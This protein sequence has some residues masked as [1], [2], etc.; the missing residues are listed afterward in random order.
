MAYQNFYSESD[1]GK[2]RSPATCSGKEIT[3]EF[4]MRNNGTSELTV[5]CKGYEK[6]DGTL[7]TVVNVYLSDGSKI[8]HEINYPK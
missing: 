5:E 8:V 3:S 1:N 6:A 2:R 4:R 7:T